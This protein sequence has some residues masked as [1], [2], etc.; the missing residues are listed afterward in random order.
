MS[1]YCLSEITNV[2]ED[3]KALNEVIEL[4]L[5]TMTMKKGTTKTYKTRKTRRSARPQVRVWRFM[6]MA[7]TAPSD[8]LGL[9]FS[10]LANHDGFH[11]MDSKQ[12]VI[13]RYAVP[14]TCSKKTSLTATTLNQQV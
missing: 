9:L 4:S 8:R 12:S 7:A 5:R 13:G 14:G 11:A 3:Q 10:D 6:I 2:D 1:Q